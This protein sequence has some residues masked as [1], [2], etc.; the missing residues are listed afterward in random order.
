MVTKADLTPS[1]CE[2]MLVPCALLLAAII[3]NVPNRRTSRCC[4]VLVVKWSKDVDQ[5]FMSKTSKKCKTTYEN[6]KM[7]FEIKDCRYKREY[8]LW[9]A[10]KCPNKPT[11]SLKLNFLSV[12]DQSC[13]WLAIYFGVSAD[14]P[15]SSGLGQW[16]W[17]SRRESPRS[18]DQRFH[19]GSAKKDWSFLL[20]QVKI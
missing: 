19:P 13:L 10:G 18:L 9:V 12:S 15:S 3:R 17:S 1:A 14:L 7:S 6:E 5:M 16:C 8:Y 4:E 20:L 2:V 11:N